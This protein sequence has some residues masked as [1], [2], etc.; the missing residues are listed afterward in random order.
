MKIKKREGERSMNTKEK[1][2]YLRE[3][4]VRHTFEDRKEAVKYF[5]ELLKQTLKDFDRQD[6]IDEY[7]YPII[8]PLQE[9]KSIKERDSSL[10]LL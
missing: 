6:R 5:K 9:F 3:G 1:W 4:E 10:S 7:D 2:I 8:I